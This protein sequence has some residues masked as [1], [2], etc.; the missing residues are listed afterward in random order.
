M[1][2]PVAK[3]RKASGPENANLEKRLAMQIIE[4]STLEEMLGGS[5]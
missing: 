5:F 1:V 3:T 2:V 4:V